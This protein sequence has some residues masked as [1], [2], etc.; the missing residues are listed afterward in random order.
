MLQLIPST[1]HYSNQSELLVVLEKLPESIVETKLGNN[2]SPRDK[3]LSSEISICVEVR[4]LF[5]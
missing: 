4:I 1:K 3:K 2:F 5:F